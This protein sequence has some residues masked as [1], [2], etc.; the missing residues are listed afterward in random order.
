MSW[1]SHTVETVPWRQRVRGGSREDRMLRAIDASVPPFIADLEHPLGGELLTECRQAEAAIVRLDTA[2]GNEFAPLAALLTRTE[3]VSSSKIER[4]AASMDDYARAV[5]GSKANASATSMVAAGA[6]LHELVTRSGQ[7]GRIELDDILHAHH[8]LMRDDPVD[9]ASAGRLRTEQNW[10]LGSD[11]SPRG[12]IHIPPVPE[13]V[14]GLM[15]DLLA[16]ANRDGVPPIL[17]AAVVHAQFESIHP[18]PDGNGRIGRALINAVLRRS[19]L[20]TRVVV[21]IASAM[22]ANREQYFR[23]VN[24]YRTGRL[25][26]FISLLAKASLASAEESW[27][28]GERLRAI[29]GEWAELSSP[30]A[31]SAASK[32]LEV[33][34]THPV[35]L[36]GLAEELT[37]SPRSSVFAALDRLEADGIIHEVTG[38]KQDRVYVASALMDELDD[39]ERRISARMSPDAGSRLL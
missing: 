27:I 12:A 11:H 15:D 17:Q 9:G 32:L 36:S 39:L 38:R 19:G 37:G 20:T 29:P 31:G 25:D 2:A 5:G 22:V 23:L 7:S 3:A 21:P 1:P 30:R 34:Q 18:F 26:P 28:S 13:R 16:Y 35:M 33:L 6:A 14:P 8:I 10:I 4:V 24:E